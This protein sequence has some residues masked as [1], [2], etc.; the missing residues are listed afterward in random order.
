MSTHASA[1]K[2]WTEPELDSLTVE[3]QFRLRGLEVTRLD[4]FVDAT[5]AFV[6]TMLVISFDELPSTSAELLSAIKRIP[7]F[8]ASFATLMMFWLKHRHWSRRYGLE[9]SAT[10]RHSLILIFV[11]LVYVYPLRMIFE[12]LFSQISNGY[13]PSSFQVDAFADIRIM[14]ATYSIGFFALALLIYLLFRAAISNSSL[15][16][17]NQFELQE[18]QV[19]MQVWAIAAGFGVF[20][21]L[22]ALCLPDR[23]IT[24]AGYVY[25]AFFLAS[26][27]PRYLAKRN[28]PSDT[29]S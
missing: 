6:L 4:T 20:S 26:R 14:F 24:L 16:A 27:I 5:F 29:T 3:E 19:D 13:L 21:V 1:G 7:A 17:L 25:F 10:I 28:A 12:G 8:A 11:M 18:T 23:Y 15:L 9:N 2:Q 22:L